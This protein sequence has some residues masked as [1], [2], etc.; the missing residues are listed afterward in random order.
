LRLT[1]CQGGLKGVEGIE[2]PF[3]GEKSPQVLVSVFSRP[4]LFLCCIL[5]VD[6]G[7]RQSTGVQQ[8]LSLTMFSITSV[9][10]Q[11]LKTS[12]HTTNWAVKLQ[13]R[14]G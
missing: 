2:E 11:S 9:N 1:P 8:S 14:E 6:G 7:T 13:L 3:G 4:A 5:L 10:P 12:A